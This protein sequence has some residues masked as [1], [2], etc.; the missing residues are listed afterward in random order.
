[1]I[2]ASAQIWKPLTYN[3][4]FW[5]NYSTGISYTPEKEEAEPLAQERF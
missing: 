5:S 4:P 2:Q 3:N 1:M